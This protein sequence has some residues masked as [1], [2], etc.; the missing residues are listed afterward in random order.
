MYGLNLIS[1]FLLFVYTVKEFLAVSGQFIALNKLLLGTTG[2]VL[3]ED[4]LL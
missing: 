1:I 4:G 2:G 3:P